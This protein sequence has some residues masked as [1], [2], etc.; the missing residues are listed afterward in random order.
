MTHSHPSFIVGIGGSAGALLAYRE[1]LAAIPVHTG[2]AFVIIAHMDPDQ[3]SLL[4]GILRHYTQMPVTQASNDM[5]IEENHIYV[6]PPNVDL[7]VKNF[8]FK[9]LSPRTMRG[10]KHKQV[11]CFF[12]SLS[13]AM[14]SR[15]IGI[16]VSG[17]DGDGTE[18][19]LAIKSKGGKTFAQDMSAKVD[20][21]PLHAEASGAVDFV[22]STE[23]IAK[24]LSAISS[25][26]KGRV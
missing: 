15:A 9:V 2:M 16:I 3:E 14:G 5:P 17:Y 18:G 13:E 25:A 10:G 8:R 1:L 23:M 20:S 7:F 26:V 19:C 24:Q 12:K 22:M 4:P 11:D 6:I 21:M